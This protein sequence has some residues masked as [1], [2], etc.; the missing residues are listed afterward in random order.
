VSKTAEK[1]MAA[2]EAAN[3]KIPA[4]AMADH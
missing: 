4:S 3:F 2:M 1:K